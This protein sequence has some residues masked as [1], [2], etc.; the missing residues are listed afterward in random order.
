MIQR[1]ECDSSTPLLY[2]TDTVNIVG[3]YEQENFLGSSMAQSC[4]T[5]LNNTIYLDQS[6]N[7]VFVFLFAF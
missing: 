5:K 4:Y 2:I 6:D 1:S 7:K 3:E